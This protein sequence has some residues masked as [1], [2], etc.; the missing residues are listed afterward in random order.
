MKFFEEI[1]THLDDPEI[2][3]NCEMVGDFNV[4]L[5]TNMDGVGGKPK[6]K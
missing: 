6:L 4:V 3:T 5:D 1:Q 2:E